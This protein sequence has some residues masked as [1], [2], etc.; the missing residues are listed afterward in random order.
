MC[1]RIRSLNR[2]PGE[3]VVQRREVSNAVEGCVHHTT[4]KE[5]GDRLRGSKQLPTL[6]THLEHAHYIEDAGKTV[7]VTYCIK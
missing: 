3:T 7:H 2:P 1:R 4:A 5:Q 6:A